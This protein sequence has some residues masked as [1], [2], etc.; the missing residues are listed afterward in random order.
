MGFTYV[1][2]FFRIFRIPACIQ[3]APPKQSLQTLGEANKKQNIKSSTLL[4]SGRVEHFGIVGIGRNIIFV[5][6][7]PSS[8]Y[9]RWSIFGD[10]YGVHGSRFDENVGSSRNHPKSIG[11][12]QESLISNLGLI[13]TPKYHNI[14][15]NNT[16]KSKKSRDSFAVFRALLNSFWALLDPWI[17]RCHVVMFFWPC[18][19]CSP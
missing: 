9:V 16:R 7:F 12:H 6:M 17:N 14:L 15:L 11:I 5:K 8:S 3:I 4:M 19:D 10:E 2:R 13:K 1:L 18:F